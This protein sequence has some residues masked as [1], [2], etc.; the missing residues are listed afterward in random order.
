M[1][2]PL[3]TNGQFRLLLSGDLG[4]DYTVETSEDLVS[5]QALFSTNPLTIFFLWMD[6]GASNFPM[7]FY[8]VIL[9]P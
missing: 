3:W 9:G 7:R 2:T 4:P 5:W 8:R 1:S 6:R